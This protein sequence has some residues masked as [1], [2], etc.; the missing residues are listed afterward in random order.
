M[1]RANVEIA[2]DAIK[3][4]GSF[5][6]AEKDAL[7]KALRTSMFPG[8]WSI[9]SPSDNDILQ[10]DSATD[11]W[12]P[13]TLA[14]STLLSLSDTPASY[15]AA[16][17]LFVRVNS[18]PDAV[19]FTTA[20]VDDL[21][22]VVEGSPSTNDVLAYDGANWISAAQ[23]VVSVNGA[24]GVVV[25][26]IDDV[27][28]TTTKGDI[29]VEDGSNAIRLAIGTDTHVLTADS[30][31]ATG[32]K[33]AASPAGFADPMTTRGDI[34]Y[35]DAT[36]TTTRLGVGT[37]GQV[38]TS[39]GTDFAWAASVSGVTA[40]L[41]LSDTPGSFATHA[42]KLVKVNALATALEF[43]TD[44]PVTDVTADAPI[45]STGGATPH[46]DAIEASAGVSG[47]LSAA[48][49]TKLDGI[50]NLAD[51]TDATNVAAAGAYMGA[52]TVS[53]GAPSGGSNGDIHFEI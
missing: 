12:S 33:W 1:P 48:W 17:G 19:E 30:A 21:S 34:I 42:N 22:D 53:T 46:I 31:E 25:L 28:P 15:A 45:Q 14:G 8:N 49:A 35:K 37:V 3:R 39:D 16:G 44:V 51:V 47:V 29:I 7:Q 4:V 52:I 27:T 23:Q 24:T 38:L 26:D 9:D 10:Y 13:T 6:E 2:L 20:A 50:E 11:T 18:T 43:S 40:W 5:S 41:G 36:N 32:I